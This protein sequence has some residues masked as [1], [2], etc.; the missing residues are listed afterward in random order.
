M[1]RH[2]LGLIT[3]CFLVAAFILFASG[4]SGPASICFKSGLVLGAIWLAYPQVKDL[5]SR[6]PNWMKVAIALGLVLFVISP[7]LLPLIIVGI[8]ITAAF[9]FITYLFAPMPKHK[10]SKEK[11]SDS[12]DQNN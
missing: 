3:L 2:L 6:S 11:M 9:Q 5:F 10:R 4:S 8:A 1:R 7:K 12:G